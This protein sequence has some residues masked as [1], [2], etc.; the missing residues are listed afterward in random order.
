MVYGQSVKRALKTDHDTLVSE[1]YQFYL[2]VLKNPNATQKEKIEARRRADE[3]LGL[4]APKKIA[5]TTPDG[6]NPYKET[7]KALSTEQLELLT[8]LQERSSQLSTGSGGC[9]AN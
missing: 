2:S 6:K 8:K 7:V 5:Q 3:L 1:S 4:N 9:S